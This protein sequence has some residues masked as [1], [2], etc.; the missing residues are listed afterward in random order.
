[1]NKE[2]SLAAQSQAYIARYGVTPGEASH[3]TLLRMIEDMFADGLVTQ[4]EPFPETDREFSRLLD[5]LRPLD[6]DALREKLVVS[7]WLL[8]PYGCLLYT[9]DAADE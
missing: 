9:S 1:M 3:D 2:E 5:V 8:E 7:G 6:A 4:V